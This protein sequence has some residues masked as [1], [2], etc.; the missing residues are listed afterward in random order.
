MWVSLD[1][2]RKKCLWAA[3]DGD[4][5]VNDKQDETVPFHYR[6]DWTCVLSIEKNNSF[7]EAMDINDYF[8]DSVIITLSDFSGRASVILCY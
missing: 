8:L 6:V 2:V 5:R 1:C 3:K 4:N 7:L